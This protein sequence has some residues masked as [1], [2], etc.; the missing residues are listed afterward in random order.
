MPILL[1]ATADTAGDPRPLAVGETARYRLEMRLPEGGAPNFEVTD[2]L[3]T[4]L[5]YVAG[6]SRIAFVYNTGTGGTITA[7]PGIV[8]GSGTLNQN[9]DET[10]VAGITP[11]CAVEP[12]GGPFSSGTDPFWDFGDLTNTDMDAN[13]E[14]VLIEFDALAVN[15]TS[16][17]D[18]TTLANSYELSIDGTT[19]TSPSVFAEI[20]EPQLTLTSVI[21][22][23][24]VDNRLDPT[25]TFSWDI[26]LA[27]AGSATAFQIDSDGGGNWELVLPVGVENIT[28]LSITL[29]GDVF[30]NGT[31]T[32][33]TVGDITLATTNNTNDTLTFSAPM[34]MAAGASLLIEFDA[35]LLASV[36]PGDAPTFTEEVVYA[37]QVAGD[38][39]SGVR[40][41][42]DQGAGTG[43]NPITSTTNLN[44]Y[45]TEVALTVPTT[46]ENPA[47][48]VTK[49]VTTGPTN[50]GDGSF[51]LTYTI[52][53]T[54]SGDVGLENVAVSDNLDTTFG[55]G[56][57]TVDDVRVASD[58]ATLDEDTG[59]TGN[60][61]TTALLLPGT[62]TLPF[63]EGGTIEIDLTVTPGANLGPLTNTAIGTS[64]SDRSATP[65]NDNGAVNLTFDEDAE[66][67][68]AKTV[69]AGPTNNNDGTY[70]LTY[71][72]NVE[73]SGSIVLDNIQV[74]DFLDTT[75]AGATFVVDSLTSSDFTVDLGYDGLAAGTP[76]NAHW[77]RRP[78][79]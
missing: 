24:P 71:R 68:I 72:F 57:Y 26:T 32:P 52:T 70:T 34:Q 48:D 16:N 4:G 54:N 76:T 12:T 75:F 65:A 13:D 15:E 46:P 59:F 18:G 17:Q 9:G 6:T 56:T 60:G 51:N 7:V 49:A 2:L 78:N 37:G 1:D 19:S 53:L 29:V 5:Q 23:T 50:N 74:T 31:A 44:D 58:S 42:A 10:T 43:N 63:G 61:G 66:I 79:A 77:S 35:E 14:F 67:G 33:V 36:E 22:P 38:S 47:L 45:R 27:N 20:A 11:D 8:C 30:L 25:P 41:D 64:D 73:N 28:G 21:T 3:P 55:A 69:L 62:S 40:D 39:A